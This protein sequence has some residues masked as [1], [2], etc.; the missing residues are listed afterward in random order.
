MA[1]NR[2]LAARF[3]R[4]AA[5]K[6]QQVDPP[7]PAKAPAAQRE[8]PKGSKFTVIFSREEA[9]A[10]D[11]FL[12]GARRRLGRRVDKSEV[13]RNLLELTYSDPSLEQQLLERLRKRG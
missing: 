13:L 2:D 4:A 10:F 5:P 1:S 6:P 8:E 11:E 3:G 9:E 12:L 7:A